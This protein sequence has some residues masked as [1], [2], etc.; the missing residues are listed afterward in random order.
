VSA[1]REGGDP[2]PA[3]QPP[4]R[5]DPDHPGTP[6][7]TP[8]GDAGRGDAGFEFDLAVTR[9]EDVLLALPY[10]RA[11]PELH[12]LLD[13]A[14][15]PAELL[16]RDERVLKVLHEAIAARPYGDIDA[17]RSTR[18][19]VEL[20]TLEVEVL[21]DRLAAPTTDAELRERTLAR[22]DEVRQRLDEV[23]GQL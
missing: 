18:T 2:T 6:G 8:R 20:L 22:L 10:D 15:V 12:V 16:H 21:T 11:L 19:E 13:R 14:G 23:R 1:S 4:G 7:R 9:L 17:V 5:P 3:F